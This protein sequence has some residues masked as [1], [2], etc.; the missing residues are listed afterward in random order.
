MAKPQLRLP[1]D[2]TIAFAAAIISSKPADLTVREY[3]S[4]LTRHVAKGR[5]ENALSVAYRHLDRSAYWRAEC[6]R[7]KAD[8]RTAEEARLEALREVELLKAKLEGAKMVAGTGAG[9][10]RK[11]AGGADVAPYS[12]KV[13]KNGRKELEEKRE[14][15]LGGIVIEEVDFGE[16]DGGGQNLMRRLFQ[17]GLYF[18]PGS[19][20]EPRDL[21][22]HLC[23]AADE[24]SEVVMD[25]IAQ[26]KSS[27]PA[28]STD[29]VTT[30]TAVGRVVAG[31]LAGLQKLVRL[32]SSD[33]LN[34]QV[35]YALVRMYEKILAQFDAVSQEKALEESP[36]PAIDPKTSV[37]TAKAKSKGGPPRVN[38]K[39]VP[40]LN[41]L[42]SLLSGIMK[43]LDPKQDPHRDI[44]EGFLFYILSKLGNRI[45]TVN[46]SRPRA[47]DIMEELE[48]AGGLDESD[49]EKTTS[50]PIS[51]AVRQAQLEAPYLLHLLRQSLA[52]TTSF[53]GPTVSTSKSAKTKSYPKPGSITKA[54]LGLAAKERL[55]ATLVS[56]IFGSE[57]LDADSDLFVECL[58]MPAAGGSAVSVP[59][60]KE[61]EVGEWF[62]SEVWRLLGWEVLGREMNS[63]M[64]E[65]Q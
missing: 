53:L 41:A 25:A 16:G 40:T 35:T 43:Q 55:Q 51:T 20:V 29:L 62:Y 36:G 49:T 19:P 9:V 60:V 38:I 21:T 27:N 30:M 6:E 45:Y 56:A 24:C 15:F 18:K 63:R 8:C 10:K 22:Q 46:F 59:K 34:G 5:R 4:L 7:A 48:A 28:S 44:F 14:V 37:A 32:D 58:R 57:S 42:A 47:E 39:N 23:S 1:T 12:R 2:R 26:Q 65:G 64:R 54:T 50:N 31:I 17:I 13:A 52:L 11:R 33:S 61:V 3:I